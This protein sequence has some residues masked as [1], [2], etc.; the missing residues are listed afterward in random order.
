MAHLTYAASGVN[1]P[2]EK[3]FLSS[4]QPLIRSTRRREVLQETERFAGLFALRR[5]KNPILVSGCDGVGTKLRYAFKGGDHAA[6]GVDC[7]AMNVNDV[8]TFGAEPLFFLDYVAV[9]K[10]KVRAL[11]DLFKGMVRGCREAGCTLLGGEL[12]Q[13][14]SFYKEGEYDISGFCV[15]VVEKDKLIDGHGVKKGDVILGLA[16][17]GFHSN[18]FSLIRKVYPEKTTPRGAIRKL[19]RPT[20]LYVKPVL[21][22]TKRFRVKAISHITGGGLYNRVFQ[23]IPKNRHALLYHGSWPIPKPF[24]DLQKKGR[25]DPVTMFTTFNMGIGMTVAVSRKD[26]PAIQSTLRRFRIPSWVIG[27]IV[28]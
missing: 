3:S 27:E 25:I 6:V 12:A 11:K 28:G 10:L 18:G 8:I 20:R 1:E 16:S 5:Y 24:L 19:L 23:G 13:M 22:L 14:P 7:V 21:A 4:V 17:S 15:G 26:V 2:L 9:G